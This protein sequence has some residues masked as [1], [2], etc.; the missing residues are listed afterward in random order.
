MEKQESVWGESGCSLSAFI[1]RPLE[2]LEGEL[3]S[4]IGER[5]AAAGVADAEHFLAIA[6]V[7][8]VE[9]YL[10]EYL[11]VSRHELD[12]AL[13]EIRRAVP[14]QMVQSLE[15]P[16]PYAYGL[17]VAEPTSEMLTEAL[18][19]S[20]A[21]ADVAALPASVN[22]IPWMNAVRNQGARGTCVA[23]TVTAMREYAY[24]RATGRAIDLSEQHLYFET[25]QIDGRP[26]DCGTFQSKAA[27]ALANRGQCL[28]TI[29]PYNPTP[30]CNNHGVLPANARTNALVH[31]L[32][33]AALGA[34]DV[35]SIK[36]AVAAGR[37][38][39]I[40]IPVYNSWYRSANT[41][42]TGQL[43]M[44]IGTEPSV[45]GHAICVVGY[46]DH[47]GTPGGGFFIIRNSWSTNWGSLSPY[48]A[49]YGTIPFQ[50]VA[51]DNWEAYTPAAIALNDESDGDEAE[52][53]KAHADART[54]TIRTKG[55][56]NLILE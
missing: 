29:W 56:I 7:P 40:S 55:N 35:G 36:A 52:N 1:G 47:V 21:E 15:S 4:G 33:L 20:G 3:K 19:V 43:N 8:E 13:R 45:G 44:R 16:L 34:R 39:G 41:Q 11:G 18:A 50:Y 10:L 32:S 17:G 46:Q 2:S 5:L 42:R 53:K 48:G 14:V 12:V 31:R 25:K 23:Y 49:G 37:P 22:L 38:V 30:P 51:N 6:A 24:R 9:S 54:I 28:E 27:V 26:A